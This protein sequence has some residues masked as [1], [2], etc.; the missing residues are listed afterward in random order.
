MKEIEESF[1]LKKKKQQKNKTKKCTF[2][3]N[4]Y[5]LSDI[6]IG[7]SIQNEKNRNK[8]QTMIRLIN[9]NIFIFTSGKKK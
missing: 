1:F 6:F 2:F 9:K 5:L 3:S 7:L 4:F 8:L